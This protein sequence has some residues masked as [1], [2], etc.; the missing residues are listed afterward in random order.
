MDK[1]EQYNKLRELLEQENNWP[2]IYMFKFI[3]PADNHKIALIESKF[4]D[5]AIIS[6]KASSSGKY[7]SITVKEV[8]LNADSIISKYREMEGIEG[9]MAI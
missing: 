4:S 8:M 2:T 3:I 7:F 9:L 5:E 6:H 1:S